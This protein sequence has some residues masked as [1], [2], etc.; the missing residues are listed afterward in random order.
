[1]RTAASGGEGTDGLKLPL[2]DEGYGSEAFWSAEID[3]AVDRVKEEVP[4]WR[5]NLARYDGDKPQLPGIPSTAQ[6][7]VNVGFYTVE[8]KKPQLFHQQPTLQ[9]KGLRPETRPVAPVVKALMDALLGEDM[10]DATAMMDEVLSNIMVP[11]GI[12]P[13]KIGYESVTVDVTIPTARMVPQTDPITGAPVPKVDPLTGQ[14]LIDPM[15]GGPQMEETL[16]LGQDG[17][18]ETETQPQKIWCEYYMSVISPDDFLCPV[19]F[20]STRYDAAPWLG[21][22]FFADREELQRRYGVEPASFAD[23]NWTERLVATADREALEK[24]SVACGYEIWYRAALYDPTELNP[25][26]LRRLVF[27]ARKSSRN[28]QA[29]VVHEDSPWQRFDPVGR[30][31]GGMRGYPIHVYTLRSRV[32]SAY[33]K[34]DCSVVRDIADEKNIG[35]SQMSLQRARSMPMR[36]INIKSPALTRDTVEQIESGEYQSLIKFE[37]AVSENDIRAIGL[38]HFPQENFSFDSITQQDIDRLTASGANQQGLPLED[39]DTAYEASLI[40]RATESRQAKERVRLL[41]QYA[42]ACQ[43]LFSLVQL[44]ATDQELVEIVG[45]DGKNRFAQWD[46]TT[47]QGPFGFSFQPDSSMRIDAAQNRE[48]MLRFINLVSN[49]PNFNQQEVAGLLCDAFGQ[50]RVPLIN[51]PAPPKPEPPKATFSIKG[52]DLNPLSPQYI[53][54]QMYLKKFYGIELPPAPPMPPVPIKSP[55]GIEPV[56]KHDT[57]NTGRLPGPGPM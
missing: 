50:D 54:V 23:I 46:R 14:P 26:R 55:Q 41:T 15:T 48:L 35:R 22:R 16:A 30:F 51:P 20:L 2:P 40:Q 32:N 6:M 45:E 13:T 1:M 12:G 5:A 39:S 11:A 47:I 7:N 4:S 56:S 28:Q 24:R 8:Q 25:E 31:I 42:R 49:N 21:F 38:A 10:I 27:L 33:P 3:A 29:V 53:G 36:G 37:G 18:P 43:K 17:Q 34:S 19:G 52:E 9:V 44:F 57:K